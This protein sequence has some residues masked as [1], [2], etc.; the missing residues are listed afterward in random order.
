[1]TSKHEEHKWRQHKEITIFI[2]SAEFCLR[3]RELY[4]KNRPAVRVIPP[5][6]GRRPVAGVW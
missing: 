3:A 6:C 4:A 5:A 2:F 1:M